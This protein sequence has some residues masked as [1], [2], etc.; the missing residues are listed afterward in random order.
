MYGTTFVAD[1]GSTAMNSLEKTLNPQTLEDNSS[2]VFNI[3]VSPYR[4]SKPEEPKTSSPAPTYGPAQT[5]GALPSYMEG[6]ST[7]AMNTSPQSVEVFTPSYYSASPPTAHPPPPQPQQLPTS[8]AASIPPLPLPPIP[9][10][11]TAATQPPSIPQ[12]PHIDYYS[13]TMQ[14]GQK[15][16][17]KDYKGAKK[18]EIIVTPEGVKKKFNGKQW[19]RLCGI[20]DCWKESQKCGL[21]S[22]HLNSPVPNLMPHGIGGPVKRSLSTAI[23]SGQ[24]RKSDGA[25]DRKSVV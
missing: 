19:R 6:S 7:P 16:R 1:S 15:I 21:C 14:R 2:S 4:R 23:D 3:E 13:P 5:L 18:G 8:H 24:R 22:K 11:P 17:L 10:T 25:I 20:E 12:S 9:H